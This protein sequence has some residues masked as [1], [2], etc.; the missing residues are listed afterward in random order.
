MCIPSQHNLPDALR[1]ELNILQVECELL[2][3]LRLNLLFVR[4]K[5]GQDD[6]GKVKV[7]NRREVLVSNQLDYFQRRKVLAMAHFCVELIVVLIVIMV[8]WTVCLL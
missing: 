8:T 4:L 3:R 2:V 6:R 1:I 7:A 5:L